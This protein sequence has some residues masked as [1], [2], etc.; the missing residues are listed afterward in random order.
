MNETIALINDVLDT[1]SQDELVDGPTELDTVADRLETLSSWRLRA[2]RSASPP[3]R[4][5]RSLVRMG[6][7]TDPDH[8]GNRLGV[9]IHCWYCF[10]T[11]TSHVH[12]LP[13]NRAFSDS[14]TYFHPLVPSFVGTPALSR[15][16]VVTPLLTRSSDDGHG[17]A[18]ALDRS[19]SNVTPSRTL[20]APVRSDLW[21]ERSRHGTGRQLNGCTPRRTGLRRY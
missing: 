5:R 4:H 21:G 17:S 10:F 14:D 3:L 9:T 6:R 1:Y 19:S 12:R 18:F 20:S 11:P 13:A 2:L 15:V 16:P 8:N 7:R